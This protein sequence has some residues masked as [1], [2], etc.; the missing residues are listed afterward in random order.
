MAKQADGAKLTLLVAEDNPHVSS[1]LQNALSSMGNVVTVADGADAL[2][3]AAE[4][5]PDIVIADFTLPGLDG[6]HLLEKLR[7]RSATSN[8]ACVLMAPRSDLDQMPRQT[9]ELADEII[10]KPF[11]IADVIAAI[12]KVM[13]RVELQRVLQSG[14]SVSGAQASSGQMRG[15]IAQLSLVDLLQALELGGKTCR[16]TITHRQQKCEVFVEQGAA[17]RADCGNQRGDDAVFA[18]L[19]WTE[20]EFEL[21]FNPKPAGKPNIQRT[22]QA[23]LM[24]GLRILDEARHSGE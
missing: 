9:R 10:E 17:V 18:A 14:A 1:L 8:V 11:L 22:T 16:V 2:L 6:L 15:N 24:D 5:R 23:L 13:A 21:D 3:R 4:Q 7:S 19:A 12:R 20:G